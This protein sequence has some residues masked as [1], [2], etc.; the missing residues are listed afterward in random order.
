MFNLSVLFRTLVP[1]KRKRIISV[2]VRPWLERLEERYTPTGRGGPVSYTWAGPAFGVWD[3]RSNWTTVWGFTALQ[4]P[5]PLDTLNFNGS[6]TNP[7][8]ADIPSI[9]SVNIASSFVYNTRTGNGQ[10][11]IAPNLALTI[12]QSLSMQG[13]K[14]VNTNGAD[15]TIRIARGATFVWNGG[16]IWDVNVT[17][18]SGASW[19]WYNG[20]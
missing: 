14:I 19:S 2:R 17:I 4:V 20:R 15:A 11:I 1:K 9:A 3:S 7:S 6:D 12:T 18:A 5:G 10:I 13:G 16:V 8:V